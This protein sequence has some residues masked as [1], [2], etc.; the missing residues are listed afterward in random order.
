[1]KKFLL[2]A[3]MAVAGVAVAA[4]QPRAIGLRL[5]YGIEFSYEHGFGESNMLSVD[6]GCPG[7]FLDHTFGGEAVVTYDWI[8]PFGADF[9]SVWSHK[10]EWNWYMGVGAG[11]GAYWHQVY[12]NEVA[13][14]A[15]DDTYFVGVAGRVGVE[16]NFWFPL[17]LSIDWRPVI[18]PEFYTYR[19]TDGRYWDDPSAENKVGFNMSGLYMGSISLAVRYKF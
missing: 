1:M 14:G 11:V 13:T 8:N 6:A 10:G 16:Y 2:I 15:W 4:A 19:D 18:G 17:Q 7:L 9:S 12:T 5:G 3:I